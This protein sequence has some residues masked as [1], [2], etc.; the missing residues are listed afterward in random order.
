MD[1][2]KKHTGWSV[3]NIMNGNI[4]RSKKIQQQYKLLA[5]ILFLLIFYIFQGYRSQ[6]QITRLVQVNKEIQDARYEFL[7]VSAELSEMTRQSAISARLRQA[8]SRVKE[9]D[10]PAIRV[11]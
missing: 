7:T 9:S 1:E 3:Q 10:T 8:D 4:F 5:L 2:K 11:K 6:R